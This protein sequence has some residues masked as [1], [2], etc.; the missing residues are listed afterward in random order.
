MWPS[1]T[2]SL[3]TWNLDPSLRCLEANT[4]AIVTLGGPF[5][6]FWTTGTS[7]E[8]AGELCLLLTVEESS[9]DGL[10]VG[11]MLLLLLFSSST[12]SVASSL[13]SSAMTAGSL[14]SSSI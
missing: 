13:D 9:T 1:W 8:L 12:F 14:V 5:L 2:N 3:K 7:L 11:R 4:S 10:V 6:S